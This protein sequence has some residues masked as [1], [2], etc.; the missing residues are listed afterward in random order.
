VYHKGVAV[1]ATYDYYQQK[2][3]VAHR[4]GDNKVAFG[5]SDPKVKMK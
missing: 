4:H 3:A 1:K 5:V 2:E